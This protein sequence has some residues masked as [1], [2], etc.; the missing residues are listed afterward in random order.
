MTQPPP[1]PYPPPPGYAPPPPGGYAVPQQLGPPVAYRLRPTGPDGRP[2]AEFGDRLLA[3]LLDSL[4]LSAILLVPMVAL[5][6]VVFIPYANAMES[7]SRGGNPSFAPFFLFF[8]GMIIGI[9]G[10]QLLA[11][12]LYQ[13]SYQIRNGQTVGKRVMKLKIVDAETGQPMDVSA[14]RKRWGITFLLGLAG[15]GAYLD[16]LWQLWDERKQTLHDKVARTVV[17]KV[18]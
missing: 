17:V 6:L 18:P 7:L 11:S 8:A 5:M 10:L 4:V 13:V 14:A 2:L 1:Q 3:Y 16:G 12:Y 15:P 9:F